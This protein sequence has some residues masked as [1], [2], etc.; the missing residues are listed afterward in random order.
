MFV[1][2]LVSIILVFLLS[3]NR[4]ST[5]EFKHSR[6]DLK[7]I[8]S[9]VSEYVRNSANPNTLQEQP[10]IFKWA[11][12]VYECRK[13]LGINFRNRRY[14]TLPKDEAAL[15]Y[16]YENNT[17]SENNIP[18]WPISPS[19]FDE[20][21]DDARFDRCLTSMDDPSFDRRITWLY[22]TD[23]KGKLHNRC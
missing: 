23:G 8:R 3:Y 15:E 19:D 17:E 5:L 21:F 14:K 13:I 20:L 7:G 18:T 10:K 9:I 11:E 2:M 12:T 22:P 16:Q 1:D 4:I 6:R